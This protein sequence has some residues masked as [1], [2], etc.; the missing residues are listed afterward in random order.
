MD[1][2]KESVSIE[3]AGF[4]DEEIALLDKYYLHTDY[5]NQNILTTNISTN[6]E[7]V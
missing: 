1:A 4:T 2:M 5:T 3:N 6:E 7:I